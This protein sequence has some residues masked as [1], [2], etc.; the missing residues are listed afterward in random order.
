MIRS[1]AVSALIS[2]HFQLYDPGSTYEPRAISKS[3]VG[4]QAKSPVVEARPLSTI[5]TPKGHGAR[6]V[7]GFWGGGRDRAK[8]L[9]HGPECMS[10]KWQ[11]DGREGE[12]SGVLVGE[13][14]RCLEKY[15][16]GEPRL[17]VCLALSVKAAEGVLWLDI[18]WRYQRE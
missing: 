15:Y 17:C 3:G 11:F 7:G 2:L 18:C 16:F 8:Q 13:D 6:G 9:R 1:V 12:Y 4:I 14:P 10:R 5:L